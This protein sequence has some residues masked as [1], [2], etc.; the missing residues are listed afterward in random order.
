ME[1]GKDATYGIEPSEK[2]PCQLNPEKNWTRKPFFFLEN[3]V[4]ID[5]SIFFNIIIFFKKSAGNRFYLKFPALFFNIRYI[6][7]K[8]KFLVYIIVVKKYNINK[9][10]RF[11]SVL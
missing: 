10:M 4:H 7:G 5:K 1:K 6:V 2:K 9:T 11:L 8:I 3:K